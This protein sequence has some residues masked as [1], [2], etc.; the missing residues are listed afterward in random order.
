MTG[1]R[2]AVLL[3]RWG[4]DLPTRRQPKHRVPVLHQGRAM[5]S[6]NAISLEKLVR[7]VGTPRC[8][9]LVDVRPDAGF[10]ADP[11]SIPGAARRPH[12]M[13]AEWAPALAGRPVVVIGRSGQALSHGAA[14]W[15]RQTG[16]VA[17]VLEGG[18]KAWTD[19]GLPLV[20]EATLPPRDG[21]GRT[22]WVTRSCPK[23]DRVA[24]PW[25]IRRFV[26]P[27]AVV[28][29]VAP[30]EVRAV[31][32]PFEATVFDVEDVVWSHRSER[33]TFDIMVEA[34]GLSTPPLDR[35]A[36]MVRAVDGGRLDLSPEAPGRLVASPGLSRLHADDL[37]QRAAWLDLFDAFYRWCRDATTETQDWPATRGA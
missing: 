35:L 16:M 11:R 32:K 33:C 6:I 17:D 26:D 30:A 37:E 14:A 10:S 22:V 9:A 13:V 3:T 31:A 25:L 34:F 4:N 20:P 28:L 24:C 1:R 12:W 19:A 7:L 29:F 23:V 8:P 2:R 5:P 27:S 15:L 21:Q 18:H 36:T